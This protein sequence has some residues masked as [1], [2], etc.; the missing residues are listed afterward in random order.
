MYDADIKTQKVTIELPVSVLQVIDDS[1]ETNLKIQQIIAFMVIEKVN[2]ILAAN[3]ALS[4]L[5]E[6]SN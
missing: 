5:P 2:D 1:N 3:E 4:D 6:G